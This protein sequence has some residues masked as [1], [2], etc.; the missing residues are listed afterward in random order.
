MCCTGYTPFVTNL[1]AG[2]LPASLPA[3]MPET[4]L[5]L[6]TLAKPYPTLTSNSVITE[7]DFTATYR[8]AKESTSLSPSGQYV[9]HYKVALKDPNLSN[10]H[11]T[12][13]PDNSRCHHL[14]I[15][16]LLKSDFNHAK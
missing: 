15:I 1:S 2:E 13:T 10:L 5:I 14:R 6:N 12:M 3:V 7:E 11:A 8:L 9:G 16:A 4:K